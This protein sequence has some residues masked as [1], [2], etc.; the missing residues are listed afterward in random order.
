M[1]GLLVWLPPPAPPRPAGRHAALILTTVG[2]GWQRFWAPADREVPLSEHMALKKDTL[3]WI[4]C[5]IARAQCRGKKVAV[6]GSEPVLE[7]AENKKDGCCLHERM[8]LVQGAHG[9]SREG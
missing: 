9:M 6:R 2:V 4:R 5:P 3:E 8:P 7:N 1:A